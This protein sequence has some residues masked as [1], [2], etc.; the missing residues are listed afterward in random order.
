MNV[1]SPVSIVAR[2]SADHLRLHWRSAA[3]SGHGTSE[4][5]RAAIFACADRMEASH[6]WAAYEQALDDAHRLGMFPYGDDVSQVA[7]A[8]IRYAS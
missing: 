7:H 2:L 8:T 4:P 1:Q 5:D 3:R 6:T